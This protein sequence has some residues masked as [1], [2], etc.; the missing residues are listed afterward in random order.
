MRGPW[1]VGGDFNSIQYAN[2]KCGGSQSNTGICHIFNSWFHSNNIV[3]LKFS[4]PQFTWSRGG[5]S[6]RLDRAMCNQDW[7]GKFVNYSVLH[8]PRVASDHRHVLV[9]FERYTHQNVDNKP[10]RFQAAWLN[11][12]RFGEFMKTSW[13]RY[14]SYGQA[15]T[16]FVRNVSDWNRNVLHHLYPLRDRFPEI[17]ETS[18][19]PGRHITENIIVAQEII[20]SMKRK[21]VQLIISCITTVQMNV[22]W[23]E[24]LTDDI[25]LSRGVRQGDPLSPYIFVLCIERLSHGIYES[26]H[27][28]RWRP[29]RLSRSGPPLSHLFFADDLL[30]LAE[31]SND[32]AQ[33]ITEVLDSFCLSSGAKVNK[34]KTQVFFSH[35]VLGPTAHALSNELGFTVTADLGKYL[36]MPLLHGRIT[37][38]TYQEI[39]DKVD[40]RL[41]GWSA[42]H[43][44]LAGR[45]TL[46]QSVLQDV[47]IY[48][49]QSTS[50]P[51]ST[52]SKL[53]QICRRFLWS[54]N[55]EYR[56]MSL[57]GWD[58]LCQPKATGGLG[59]KKLALMN[60]ALMM[61]IAGLFGLSLK[62]LWL[63][64]CC[65]N[66]GF[67]QLIL[68]ITSL[69][70][71]VPLSGRL[72]GELGSLP[73]GV[74]AGLLVMERFHLLPYH[75]VLRIASIMP[76]SPSNGTDKFFWAASP[77][78]HFTIRSAYM[79]LA[80]PLKTN[81][82]IASWGIAMDAACDR[83]GAVREDTLHVLRD[84]PYSMEIWKRLLVNGTHHSFFLDGLA[85][86]ILVEVDSKDVTQILEN[87]TTPVNEH[88]SLILAIRLQLL[89][90]APPNLQSI[91]NN[92]MSGVAYSRLVVL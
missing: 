85:D 78:G 47:L 76:L 2:E 66:M 35:N 27:Q 12:S 14:K 82:E 5:L 63:G 26:I 65:L 36:G 80:K 8:L 25:S 57:I 62:N 43:L 28:N 53:E 13:D 3:D 30:L 91:L 42:S 21:K 88:H 24:E 23:E 51:A 9:R 83:C 45:I 54:G 64:S 11:D 79:L 86:W 10:F 44:S 4:G 72:W 87:P 40:Q 31:A 67:P 49:M 20:H 18:F 1:I 70:V 68:T 61:K 52:T 32:Q 48:A 69:Q 77:S 33:F 58:R 50:L 34:T 90:V 6:K 39:L 41:S 84:C 37:K 92:D 15:A 71:R 59:F 22:L 7:L 16:E 17:E 38:A 19:V 73:D 56:K 55:E 29:I 81:C 75:V 60:K 74:F 46:T 89:T